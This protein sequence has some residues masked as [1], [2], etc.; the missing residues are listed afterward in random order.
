MAIL[1]SVLLS[2]LHN[3][4]VTSVDLHAA[5]SIA[6]DAAL[7]EA[8]GL[9]VHEKIEVFNVS[10]GARFSLP[11][12]S[13]AKNSGEIAIHGAAAHLAKA[14]DVLTLAAWGQVKSKALKKHVPVLLQ[15]DEKN[16]VVVQR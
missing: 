3:A 4:M 11:L 13:R 14:G 15:L 5:E 1:H 6:V 10:T 2:R 12:S 8:A 16:R 7:I 9:Q